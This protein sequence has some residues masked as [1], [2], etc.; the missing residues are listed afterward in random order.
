MGDFSDPRDFTERDVKEMLYDDYFLDGV[1]PFKALASIYDDIACNRLDYKMQVWGF[2]KHE[3][4]RIV[5]EIGVEQ[6][7]LLVSRS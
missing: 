5:R 6:L 7:N 3:L 4:L 1:A 2:S